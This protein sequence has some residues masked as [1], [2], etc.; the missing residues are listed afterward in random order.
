MSRYEPSSK[1]QA[2]KTPT[3]LWTKGAHSVEDNL[4]SGEALSVSRAF[5]SVFRKELEERLL[6][7]NKKKNEEQIKKLSLTLKPVVTK[8]LF[9]GI[10]FR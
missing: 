5:I 1:K 2:R 10:S 9:F 7:T 4:S 6:V 8:Y 3:I